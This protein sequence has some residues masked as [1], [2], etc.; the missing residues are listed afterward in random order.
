MYWYIDVQL[1]PLTKVINIGED[2]N[3]NE[4]NK[5]NEPKPQV[6][7]LLE[8]IPTKPPMHLLLCKTME[9]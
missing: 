3:A 2:M 5:I 1:E 7:E 4:E 9:E 6:N 8:L